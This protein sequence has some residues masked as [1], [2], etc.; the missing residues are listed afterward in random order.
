MVDCPP[1]SPQAS[2]QGSP[3]MFMPPLEKL[4]VQATFSVLPEAQQESTNKEN[5]IGGTNNTEQ[6]TTHTS[7]A[8]TPPSIGEGG[9][10][11]SGGGGGTVL[12]PILGATSEAVK[13]K[14]I[15]KGSIIV[16]DQEH[17][18]WRKNLE[19]HLRVWELQA[20]VSYAVQCHAT[21][22]KRDVGVLYM[23]KEAVDNALDNA[24]IMNGIRTQPGQSTLPR[25]TTMKE[26]GTETDTDTEANKECR[27]R[28][29]EEVMKLV[30]QNVNVSGTEAD[31]HQVSLA[32]KGGNP[33]PYAFAANH[34]NHA[35]L[36][37]T[38]V[39]AREFVDKPSS[40]E[41]LEQ[42][43]KTQGYFNASM[44]GARGS[45]SEAQ[46]C[47]N[48]AGEIADAAKH[49]TSPVRLNQILTKA[50]ARSMV[51]KFKAINAFT[52]F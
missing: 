31:R 9:D 51:V 26:D 2:P 16:G 6:T 5:A 3:R 35:A 47:N 25:L 18:F 24:Y 12:P 8:T 21:D 49:M 28:H 46:T 14:T 33:S 39:A 15:A 45:T 7:L 41:I 36:K 20:P 43:N 17:L 44:V 27:D 38:T 11:G 19:V 10:G 29:C 13:K 22:D 34:P 40:S 50:R 23:N 37:T 4:T 48:T 32:E 1:A 30:L 42:F 52:N